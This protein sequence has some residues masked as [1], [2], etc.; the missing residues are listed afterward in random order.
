MPID[1]TEEQ[2]EQICQDVV[3]DRLDQFAGDISVS[4]EDQNKT[5]HDTCCRMVY[6][7]SWMTKS[8]YLIS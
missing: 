7:P 8:Q 4:I 6:T 1:I 3:D 2:N 5:K